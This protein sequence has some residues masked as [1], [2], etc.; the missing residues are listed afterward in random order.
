MCEKK[1]ALKKKELEKAERLWIKHTQRNHFPDVFKW[2]HNRKSNHFINQLG[3]R[4]D[5]Y[6]V[7]RCQGRM[8]NAALTEGTRFPILLPSND[9]LTELVIEDTHARILHSGVSQTLST[10]RLKYWIIRGRAS[11]KKVLRKCVVCKRLEGGP[12]KMPLMAP[13]PNARVSEATPFSRTGLDYLGP[14]HTRDNG[15]VRKIWI[16]LFTCFV[17]RA[18]HL[19]I[20]SDM[21][22]T[23]FLFCLRRFIA[24]RGTP[25]EIVSDNAMQFKLADKTLHLIWKNIMTSE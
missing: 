19:E 21:T 25:S 23:A 22:T 2:S 10:I 6:V 8:E 14:L 16:C 7:L 5:D 11:V 15:V 3:V 24:T 13:L 18:I 12:Y 1:D 17:T 20:V 4:V 9:K